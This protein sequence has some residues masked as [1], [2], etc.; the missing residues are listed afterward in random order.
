MKKQNKNQRANILR[1][2]VW[3]MCTLLCISAVTTVYPRGIEKKPAK[4]LSSLYLQQPSLN[5]FPETEIKTED[6]KSVYA[7]SRNAF[8]KIKY[9]Q[10]MG[11][12]TW[13][14]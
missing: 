13:Y 7:R 3:Y 2:I 14:V 6:S 12:C 10:L 4:S 1:P 5:P 9:Q 11:E 8:W